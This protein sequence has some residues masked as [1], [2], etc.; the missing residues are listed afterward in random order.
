MTFLWNVD[1][2]SDRGDEIKKINKKKRKSEPQKIL[3]QSN[4]KY[5]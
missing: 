4:T 5:I 1:W 3:N 2:C